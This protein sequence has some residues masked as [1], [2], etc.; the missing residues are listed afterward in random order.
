MTE[1]ILG[2][3][4]LALV[5]TNVYLFQKM[6]DMNEKYMKA[7]MAKSLTD[8]TSNAIISKE[9]PKPPVS[10]PVEIGQADESIFKKFLKVNNGQEQPE[11]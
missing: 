11:V 8:F 9:D 10:E 5:I 7:F 2:A 3:I 6:L 4:I 1:F